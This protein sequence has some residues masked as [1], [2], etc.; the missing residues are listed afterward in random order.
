MR[1][2]NLLRAGTGLGAIVGV[3]LAASAAAATTLNITV[4]N[5][6]EPGGL[7]ATP[8]FTAIHDS[9]YDAFDAGSAASANLEALAETGA[10]GGLAADALAADA[11]ATTTVFASPAGPPPVQ[12]GESVS[13]IVDITATE[14]LFLSFLAM[15]LPSNDT[16]VGNDDPLAFQLFND[17]GEFLGD[18]VF[19][20]T[21][22][23]IYDAGTE[24]NGLTGSAFVAGQ[25]ISLGD[26][27]GGV[28]GPGQS[29]AAFAGATLATGDILGD[30]D[31]ID[32]TSRPSAFSYLTISVTEI[33]PVPL[34]ATALLMLS[35]LGLAGFGLR[36]TRRRGKAA[37]AG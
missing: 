17:A 21:G 19:T 3:S 18:R 16:F 4:I 11:D 12:P 9:S 5:T 8:V 27:E 14:A 20:I 15:V 13:Q 32:F 26:P 25:D 30:A 2:I 33:A 10:T 7:S 22:T 24:V 37:Q 6:Q 34:P 36:R 35:G 1:T 31:L 28:V 29:L 23:S